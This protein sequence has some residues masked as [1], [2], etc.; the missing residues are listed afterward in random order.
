MTQRKTQGAA[1]LAAVV[2]A[3]LW[4]LATVLSGRREAWDGGGYWMVAYPLALLAC[5]ALGRLFPQRP[6]R[7]PLLLF[8][9]QFLAL[10]VRNGELGNLWPLGLVLFGLLALPGV[11]FAALA[12]R[13]AP[14]D[15]DTAS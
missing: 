10:C 3:G 5:A 14:G 2:G 11:F 15:R 4:L 8:A 13:F 1:V 9:G 7:W 6:W 12:A